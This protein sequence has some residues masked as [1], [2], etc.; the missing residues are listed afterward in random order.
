MFLFAYVAHKY[1][2]FKGT[3][4]VDARGGTIELSTTETTGYEEFVLIQCMCYR[5]LTVG[6]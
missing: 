6:V 2:D 5:S 3:I 1:Q 4:I